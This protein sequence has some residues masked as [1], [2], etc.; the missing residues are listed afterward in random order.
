MKKLIGEDAM[1]DAEFWGHATWEE[2]NQDEDCYLILGRKNPKQKKKGLQRSIEK[3]PQGKSLNSSTTLPS[4]TCLSRNDIVYYTVYKKNKTKKKALNPFEK[5]GLNSNLV[6]SALKFGYKLPTP[7]Q[8]KCIPIILEGKD[9]VAMART[10]SGKSAAFLLPILHNLNGHCKTVGIRSII[11]EPTRELAFQIE[12]FAKQLCRFTDI[13]ICTIVGGASMTNQFEN[14]SLNPDVIIA[15]PGRFMQHIVEI[16]LNLT[17]VESVV[18]DEADQL[19]E[20]GMGE[21][22]EFIFSKIPNNKQIICMSA[23]LPDALIE[24][25]RLGLKYPSFVS[26][27]SENAL[28][29]DLNMWFLYVRATEK[30]AALTYILRKLVLNDSLTK[31]MQ[32]PPGVI[33]FVASRYHVEFFND[34]LK[35]IGIIASTVYGSMDAEA[36]L[37]NLTK[38]RKQINQVLIVTDIAARGL[39][40]P[41]VGVVIN[42]DFP[43]STKFFTHRVGRTARAGRK[44]LAISFTTRE[45]LPHLME[46]SVFNGFKLE[47]MNNSEDYDEPA[48]S[49]IFQDLQKRLLTNVTSKTDKNHFKVIQSKPIKNGSN[50]FKESNQPSSAYKDIDP[51]SSQNSLVLAQENTANVFDWN[52]K[53]IQQ[54]SKTTSPNNLLDAKLNLNP[55]DYLCSL[56]PKLVNK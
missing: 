24:F 13:K 54:T 7:V 27:D 18:L 32:L 10:G 23:T 30:V 50:L 19:F 28:S 14:L 42:F 39:D 9:L 12:K 43:T 21:Q 45:D 49:L 1:N 41:E 6:K 51:K 3:K 52:E 22:I 17:R 44:G 8:R 46:L 38:F 5:L 33:I 25:T 53:K 29:P 37:E 26:M 11:F 4:C 15:C 47:N 34:L 55:D 56:K 48:Q 2:E 35:K 20:L 16:D 40:I 36:R 31:S